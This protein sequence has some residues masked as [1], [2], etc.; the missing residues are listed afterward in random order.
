VSVLLHE[1]NAK[2]IWCIGGARGAK[3]AV[4]PFKFLE[5][6]VI[7]CLERRFSKQNRVIRLKSNSLASPNFLG[8]PKFSGWLRH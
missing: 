4:A 6:M 5:N 7:L 8:L 2:Y 1:A 3:G